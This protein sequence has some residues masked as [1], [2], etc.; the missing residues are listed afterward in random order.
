MLRPSCHADQTFESKASVR[1]P[2][3]KSL[4]RRW[5]PQSIIHSNSSSNRSNCSSKGLFRDSING[6]GR[7]GLD[8]SVS[9]FN[10]RT[11]KQTRQQ[12]SL[13]RMLSLRN[14]QTRSFFSKPYLWPRYHLILY[15]TDDLV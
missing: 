2:K 3:V 8:V 7:N 13:R 9:C 1:V 10:V 5:Q 12:A 15:F 11:L 6:T 4:L 14:A